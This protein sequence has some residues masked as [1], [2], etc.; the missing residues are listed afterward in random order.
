[1]STT[2]APADQAEDVI[3]LRDGL[4]PTDEL[5]ADAVPHRQYLPAL[6]ALRA[7]AVLGVLAYH[8]DLAWAPGGF[9]GVDVFFV[10]SGFLIT[11]LLLE[12][13]ARTGSID[14]RRFIIRRARRLLPA[15]FLVL[16]A[17]TLLVVL[18][19][20][21]AAGH[22]QR[23]LPA[24]LLYIT[25]WT[26]IATGQSYF[27]ATGRPPPLEHLWSLSL[28]EQ[29]YLLWPWVL[30]LAWRRGGTMR[31]RKWALIGA[32]ASTVLMLGYS[33]AMD[34]PTEDASRVYFGTDTHAM[35]LLLGAALATAWVPARARAT[36]APGARTIVDVVGVAALLG[37]LA[38]FWQVTDSTEFLY[39]GGF[40]VLSALVA[41]LI[42][43]VTHPASRFGP[44]LSKQP[45]AWLG[46]RSYGIYLWHWPI[47]VVTRPGIDTPIDGLANTVLR[48]AL[49]FAAAEASYRWLEQP[50]RRLGWR[51][52][53]E[54]LLARLRGL[55]R[56]PMDPQRRPVLVLG[57]VAVVLAAAVVRLYTLPAQAD[58]VADLPK[59]ALTAE[60]APAPAPSPAPT[61]SAAPE[62]ALPARPA[63]GVLAVGESVM[64]GAQQGLRSTFPGVEIDAQVALQPQEVAA[65]A[66][67]LAAG[68]AMRRD[69]VLHVGSNGYLSAAVLRQTLQSLS[70]A[71]RVALVTVSVPR[72]WQDANNAVI[73]EVAAQ[74][75]NVAVADWRA[76]VQKDRDLVVKDGIHPTGQGVT[77]YAELIEQAL[78]SVPV[79]EPK[80]TATAR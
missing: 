57:V 62:P 28:E 24:S 59:D 10:L 15:L 34:I 37:V 64:L 41:L 20:P 35:G 27:D 44:L 61:A 67:Q 79:A 43:A 68:P 51:G 9:L 30:L 19:A 21:D 14:Y 48:L 52:A 16:A 26:S 1:M 63:T 29:F 13:L 11:G 7:V 76:A 47:F 78:A 53:W 71:D 32:I 8:L 40:L 46:T 56:L 75:P 36:I 72:R 66:Q 2:A 45:M 31:V 3:D 69:V 33:L 80:G 70:A 60:P 55:S 50:V 5:R 77:T 4:A 12:S 38:A 58:Y 23:D 65:R 17:S 39:H 18:F 54:A 22:Q 6:D 49:T 25:N 42:V 74:F 73:K